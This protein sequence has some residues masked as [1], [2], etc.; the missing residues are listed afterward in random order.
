M[1]DF[2]EEP[3][4]DSVN[5]IVKNAMD[6]IRE[7]DNPEIKE[8]VDRNGMAMVELVFVSSCMKNLEERGKKLMEE[9]TRHKKRM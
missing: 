8:W 7:S 9:I 3:A 2:F 5:Y 1:D 6:A 4:E